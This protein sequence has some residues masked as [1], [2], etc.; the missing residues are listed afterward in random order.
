MDTLEE[1]KKG[2]EKSGEKKRE[3]KE[4]GRGLERKNGEK[5]RHRAEGRYAEKERAM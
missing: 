5:E 4:T 3:K 2:R 1:D